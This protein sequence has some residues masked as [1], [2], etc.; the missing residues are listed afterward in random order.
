MTEEQG[1]TV[2]EFLSDISNKLDV[3]TANQVFIM[4]GI[5]WSFFVL[6][7]IMAFTIIRALRR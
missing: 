4:D 7:L 6:L 2:I 5:R 3:V 1:T